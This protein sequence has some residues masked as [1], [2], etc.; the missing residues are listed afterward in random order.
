[1]FRQSFRNRKYCFWVAFFFCWFIPLQFCVWYLICPLNDWVH[2]NLMV[3][4]S[5]RS[6]IPQK[7]FWPLEKQTDPEMHSSCRNVW[8][9]HAAPPWPVFCTKHLVKTLDFMR[10]LIALNTFANPCK[11][12]L[13]F[14]SVDKKS[15]SN[16]WTNKWD[17]ILI[18]KASVHK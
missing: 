16:C 17:Y 8:V 11:S 14:R 6:V 12:V 3:Q 10:L 15:A 2:K 1:M 4:S 7:R 13:I 9:A 18:L 5:K